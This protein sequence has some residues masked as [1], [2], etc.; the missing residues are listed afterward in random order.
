MSRC[1]LFNKLKIKLMKNQKKQ[2]KIIAA[3]AWIEKQMHKPE[4][5]LF[6]SPYSINQEAN[7]DGK[8]RTG[9][10]IN[11]YIGYKEREDL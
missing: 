11:W 10:T 3:K 6:F 4:K 2:L 7:V 1:L 8:P 5:L 9:V